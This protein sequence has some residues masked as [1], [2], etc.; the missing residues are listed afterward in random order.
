MTTNPLPW[1]LESF[2]TD[3]GELPSETFLNALTGRNQ[4]EAI[5]LLLLLK[6]RGNELRGDHS[7]LVRPGLFEL[8]G[9]QVRIFYVFRPG[10]R[11][12]LLGGV[13]KQQD[14]IPKG[15]VDLMLARK[16]ILE[17]REGGSK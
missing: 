3:S 5:A 9:H 14:E 13:I 17:R 10:R 12:V 1:R 6:E 8:R 11:I 2:R 16:A 4:S 7:R 15:T